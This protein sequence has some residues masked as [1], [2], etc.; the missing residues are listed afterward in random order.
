MAVNY[1]WRSAARIAMTGDADHDFLAMMIPHHQGAVEMV[2]LE[3]IHGRG[4]L[5][6]QLAEESSPA[7]VPRSSR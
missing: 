7:S 4:P 6:R 3:M 1:G 5:T 2:R